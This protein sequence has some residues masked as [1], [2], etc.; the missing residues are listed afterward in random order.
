[1]AIKLAN[2]QS[3]TSIT[4]LPS[5]I[6]TGAWTLIS[7]TTASS[8]ATVSI[9]S[10]LDDTYSL[11][12]FKY[13]NLHPATNAMDLVFN[14]SI[15]SG[16]NYNVTKTT[17]YFHARHDEGDTA[18]QLT[19]LT[20]LDLAQGTGFQPLAKAVG[21][22][23]D[24]SCSGQLYLFDPSSTTFVKHFFGRAAALQGD[25]EAQD[26]YCAGYFNTTSAI[27]AIQF[28]YESGNTDAGVIKLY[29]IS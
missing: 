18:T 7:T 28:K 15:D 1:M 21:N 2:N 9:T 14:G 19:Y 27:D 29:G 26:N 10:G 6:T 23:N 13:F 25:D 20:G 3:M 17:T 12:C 22:G 8:S 11:Y 24:E 16:S 5:A 4:S